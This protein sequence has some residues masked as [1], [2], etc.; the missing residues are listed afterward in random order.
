MTCPPQSSNSQTFPRLLIQ[1]W[2]M[3]W[4]LKHLKL[5][6]QREELSLL[7]GFL[8]SYFSG[9]S[10]FGNSI[11]QVKVEDPSYFPTGMCTSGLLLVALAAVKC[12]D[13]LERAHIPDLLGVVS[14]TVVRCVNWCSISRM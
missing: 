3:N 7:E 14:E 4:F 9:S 8:Q 6:L 11:S 2:E 12:T 5:V 10:L 13:C 1:G